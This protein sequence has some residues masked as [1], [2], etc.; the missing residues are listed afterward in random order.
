M[1]GTNRKTGAPSPRILDSKRLGDLGLGLASVD[2]E[3]LL[4]HMDGVE[5]HVSGHEVGPCRTEG[6]ELVEAE[7]GHDLLM[8][9][10]GLRY[11]LHKRIFPVRVSVISQSLHLSTRF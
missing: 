6:V 9:P 4:D 8:S 3:V 10:G 5:A 2:V 1:A 7:E 11:R